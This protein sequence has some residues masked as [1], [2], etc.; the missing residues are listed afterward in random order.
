MTVWRTDRVEDTPACW[1]LLD[2]NIEPETC[3]TLC[4]EYLDRWLRAVEEYSTRALSRQNDKLPAISGLAASLCVLLDQDEYW[5]KIWRGDLARSLIWT[6]ELRPL[7]RSGCLP[8]RQLRLPLIPSWSWASFDGLIVFTSFRRVLNICG[9]YNMGVEHVRPDTLHADYFDSLRVEDYLIEGNTKV[10]GPDKFG[11][12]DGGR[13]MLSMFTRHWLTNQEQLKN[14]STASTSYPV[15]SPLLA[16]GEPSHTRWSQ[17][18]WTF[19]LAIFKLPSRE[20]KHSCLGLMLYPCE[21]R[22]YERVGVF[23][24]AMFKK[25]GW[26]TFEKKE[27]TN[28]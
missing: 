6:H 13:L 4:H 20:L 10:S 25:I 23:H 2:G 12:V 7:H 5:A 8:K 27:I 9:K 18:S 15:R 14:L 22:L 26:E 1:R 24:A 28:V 21:D 11:Q 3:R 16:L 17:E 19:V